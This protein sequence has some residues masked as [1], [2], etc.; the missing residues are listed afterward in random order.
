MESG[1]KLAVYHVLKVLGIQRRKRGGKFR[2]IIQDKEIAFEWDGA[3]LNK[4]GAIVLCE[5]ELT[6]AFSTLHIH[7]HLSRLAIM[8]GL[9]E[10]VIKL[11]WIVYPSMYK[12]L[13]SIVDAWLSG[14]LTISKVGLPPIEYRAPDGRLLQ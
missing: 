9:N 1:E 14:F 6:R 10:N 2:Y 3:G 5:V 4:N 13:K 11:I 7:G 8:I 12:K